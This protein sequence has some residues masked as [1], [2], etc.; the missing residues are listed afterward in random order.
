M[1][2]KRRRWF[3]SSRVKLPLVNTSA[4]WFFG[5]NIFDLDF[6]GVGRRRERGE[7]GKRGPNCFCQITILARHCGFLT[8]VSTLDFCL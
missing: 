2:D 6:G 5:V 7:E 4:S 1:F 3:H 8:C